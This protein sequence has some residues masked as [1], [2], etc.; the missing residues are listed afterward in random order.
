MAVLPR[1]QRSTFNIHLATHISYA[2]RRKHGLRAYWC[3]VSQS[4][5]KVKLKAPTLHFNVF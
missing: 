2:G 5:K 4:A 3:P 1:G